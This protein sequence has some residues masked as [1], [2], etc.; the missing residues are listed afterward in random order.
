MH[1][2]MLRRFSGTA[3][4][5]G[6]VSSASTAMAVPTM[7]PAFAGSYTIS[8]L[9]SVPDV[10]PLY[11]GI[12]FAAGDPNTLII[13]GFSNTALGAF[14]SV[15]LVRDAS[16]HI[17]GFSGAAT[18]FAE[19]AFNDGG[20]EYGPGGVLFYTRFPTNELGQIEPG[21]ATTDRVID[22]TALGV[23]S[24]VGA[25]GFVPAGQPG[26]GQ[27]K[28][29]SYDTGEWYSVVLSPDASGTYDVVSVTLE[30][31]L[32]YATADPEGF[33][34]VPFGSPVFVTPSILMS[35]YLSGNVG[36][37]QVD[38]N[39]D[40]ILGTRA[41]FIFGLEGAEGALI[42]PLTGDFLFS[43]FGGGDQVFV[44]QGFVAPGPVPEPGSLALLGLGLVGLAVRRRW[45]GRTRR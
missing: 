44:V 23:G 34:Y 28:I 21:S 10:P 19:G 3:L 31:D 5:L 29:V 36:T 15:G 4:A 20:L 1:T 25:L 39:G 43:T 42:D 7:A 22:L 27:L 38:S 11:G 13:G 40:P 33:V 2:S 35:E 9:G 24:S 14:Y 17:T 26:A 16:N 30:V 32:G 8:S 12:Q 18:L 45:V 6:F 37:W 41:D